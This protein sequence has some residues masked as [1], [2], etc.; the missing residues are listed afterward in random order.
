MLDAASE[1]HHI[2]P[3]FLHKQ[4]RHLQRRARRLIAVVHHNQSLGRIT[5]TVHGRRERIAAQ[6]CGREVNGVLNVSGF[7]G[8]TVIAHVQEQ[9]VI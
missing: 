4:R 7:K 6:E 9:E 1:H 3:P 2:V 5:Q 8:L